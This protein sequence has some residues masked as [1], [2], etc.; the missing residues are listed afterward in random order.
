MTAAPGGSGSGGR[1]G[2]GADPKSAGIRTRF[3]ENTKCREQRG[4]PIQPRFAEVAGKTCDTRCGSCA[5]AEFCRDRGS[6]AGVGH[7]RCH[8]HVHC[9]SRGAAE[10]LDYRDPNRLCVS[11][12]GAPRYEID[13]ETQVG[14]I[15]SRGARLSDGLL[16]CPAGPSLSG[17][18]SMYRPVSCGFWG[19]KPARTRFPCRGRRAW[20]RARG[21]TRYQRRIVAAAGPAADPQN[22]R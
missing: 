20:R 22:R 17:T 19:M 11:R 3:C 7:R 16:C 1:G 14:A 13:P 6:H 9:D 12:V 15:V 8:G 5:Q 18:A 2:R 10:A 4:E 21:P